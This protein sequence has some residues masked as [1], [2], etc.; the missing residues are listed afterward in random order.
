MLLLV[1]LACIYLSGTGTYL[2]CWGKIWSRDRLLSSFFYSTDIRA[3]A[4]TTKFQLSHFFQPMTS[5]S[6]GLL[7]W[8]C[9]W[10]LNRR[11]VDVRNFVVPSYAG[12]KKNL[13]NLGLW[14]V[15]LVKSVVNSCSEFWWIIRQAQW[16]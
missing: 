3:Y 5:H 11:S 10:L 4:S 9:D 2:I 1:Y 7:S 8:G 6:T 15:D 16:A 12:V 13:N 14:R